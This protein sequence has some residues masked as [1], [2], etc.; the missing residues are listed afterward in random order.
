MSGMNRELR[1]G[2]PSLAGAMLS[3]GA[4]I[5][6]FTTVNSFFIAPLSEAF[7]W[8]RGQVSLSSTAVLIT[9]LTMPLVG[10]LV[11]RYG[12]QR[13]ILLGS[14]L[15]ALSYAALAL[16]PGPFW[17]YC[18]I[19][20]F[21]GIGAGP[22]TAPLVVTR[23]LVSA[24]RASRGLALA[25]GMSGGMLILAV[26]I[27][28][29]QGTIAEYGWRAG[30]GLMAPVSLFAGIGSYLL[31]RAGARRVAIEP[32]CDGPMSL[33]LSG[34]ALNEALRDAR[35]WLLGISITCVS[36]VNGALAAHL[37]PLLL[38]LRVAGPDAAMLG[39]WF[40]VSV[41]AGR[42]GAGVLLDRF[43]PPMVGAIAL[44]GPVL[45]L[46]LF[47]APD[48]SWVALMVATT[49]V[50]LSSGAEGD[51]LAFFTARYFGLRS[52]GAIFGLLG[53][54]YG[55]AVA[56]AGIGAGF[57]FD[58]AGTYRPML[59]MGTVLAAVSAATMLLAGFIKARYPAQGLVSESAG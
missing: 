39:S 12:P 32:V 4:G 24:F 33:P 36:M 50:G 22:A 52:F 1:R 19:M 23:P 11:D 34:Y 35:F 29:L 41:I 9:G 31:L 43:W 17:V 47:L 5:F 59:V 25:I 8:T 46:P 21:I 7:G 26:L 51:M 54:L 10:I 42:L 27:P 53:M 58:V 15:F 45:G 56:A 57:S 28:V 49:L 3:A 18:A 55:L 48:P 44:C 30:Y 14:I 6:I 16:M 20:L 40:A 37:Q 2:W 38:D 13:F